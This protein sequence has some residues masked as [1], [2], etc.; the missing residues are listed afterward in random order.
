[1]TKLTQTINKPVADLLW[2]VVKN[3]KL[4]TYDYDPQIFLDRVGE[5]TATIIHEDHYR[6]TKNSPWLSLNEFMDQNDIGFTNR[7]LAYTHQHS[8][9]I[10]ITVYGLNYGTFNIKYTTKHNSSSDMFIGGALLPDYATVSDADIDVVIDDKLNDLLCMVAILGA[11]CK[12]RTTA[13][14]DRLTAMFNK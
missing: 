14:R 5:A 9:S 4:E 13:T 3:P 2:H 11:E 12:N 1:M 6:K 7:R 8:I 10:I